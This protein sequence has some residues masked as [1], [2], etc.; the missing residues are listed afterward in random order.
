MFKLKMSERNGKMNLNH[1]DDD[2]D[3]VATGNSYSQVNWKNV[4]YRT[5]L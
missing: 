4:T 2:G 3:D 5:E 1:D